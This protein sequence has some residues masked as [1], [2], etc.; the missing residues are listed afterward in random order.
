MGFSK[1]F[2]TPPKNLVLRISQSY[3]LLRSQKSLNVTKK[4]VKTVMTSPD[5]GTPEREMICMCLDNREVFE[6]HTGTSSQE[7]RKKWG[8]SLLL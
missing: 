2:P 3:K 4:G 5:P 7:G 6:A 1:K 8:F